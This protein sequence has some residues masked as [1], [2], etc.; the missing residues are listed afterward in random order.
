[1]ATIS[2]VK[3]TGDNISYFMVLFLEFKTHMLNV[4]ERSVGHTASMHKR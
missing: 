1:M 3:I 4:N 2:C